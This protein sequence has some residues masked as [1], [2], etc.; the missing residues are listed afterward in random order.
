[1]IREDDGKLYDFVWK[2]GGPIVTICFCHESGGRR[3]K[4][5][6]KKDQANVGGFSGPAR[7]DLVHGPG[8]PQSSK[9]SKV[10]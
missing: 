8:N 1:M 4:V 7:V 6:S 9:R 5:D 10:G 3:E 2:S